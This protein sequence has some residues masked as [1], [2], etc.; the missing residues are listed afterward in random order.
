MDSPHIG[1][2]RVVLWA[3]EVSSEVTELDDSTE[4][5]R[6][7]G[8][9]S[10]A[11]DA[12]CEPLLMRLPF[13]VLTLESED[14]RRCSGPGR[15]LLVPFLAPSTLACLSGGGAFTGTAVLPLGTDDVEAICR[16]GDVVYTQYANRKK[17]KKKGL[18]LRTERVSPSQYV[19]IN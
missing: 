13:S 5:T 14:T 4:P 10:L 18:S 9:S 17:N 11:G 16:S 3:A 2:V 7:T 6:L 1:H 12:G 19:Y 15:T 8:E